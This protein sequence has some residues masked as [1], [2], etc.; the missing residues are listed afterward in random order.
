VRNKANLGG[1]AATA[2]LP[3]W[4]PGVVVQTNP[5]G[6]RARRWARAG[7]LSL[8][9]VRNKAN[10]GGSRIG[11]KPFTEGELWRLCPS[12]RVGKT[13]PISATMPV[14]RSA[15]PGGKRAKRSQ[16]GRVGGGRTPPSLAP[17]GCCT[18]KANRPAVSAG[19]GPGGPGPGAAVQTNPI[20]RRW[21]RAK[22]SQFA[23]GR[24]RARTPN[25]RSGRGQAPRRIEGNRA[26]QSQFRSAAVRLCGCGR[27][28]RTYNA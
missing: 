26:K 18:N 14:G 12:P 28:G 23:P 27:R 22:Q 21:Q 20:S 10:F 19:M 5:I 3:L 8:P 9:I 6:R 7:A 24:C 15:F 2:S 25:P 11:A 17:K 4:S 13:K 16:F 1:P